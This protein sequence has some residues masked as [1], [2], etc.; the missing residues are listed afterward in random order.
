[1]PED[2][3]EIRY[4][5]DGGVARITLAAPDKLNSLSPA[6][7]GA[8]P[9]IV[10]RAQDGGARCILLSGEG[11]AFCS[12]ARLG[13]DGAGGGAGGRDLGNVIDT[14]YNPIARAFAD[15]SIPVVTALNG[16]AAGAGVG[17]ALS[18]DIVIAAR[19]AYLLLA[20]ANIGLVPDAGST[21]LVA[22]SVGR[23][24][25]LELALLAEKL[26]A[27]EAQTAGLIARVVSDD[28]LAEESAAVAARLASMPTRALG[29]IR[30]QVRLA[31]DA[32]LHASLEAE[33]DNQRIAG[34]TEDHREGVRA[35]MEKRPALFTG[36]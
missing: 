10:G 1:M 21:W 5:L 29:M 3:D 13:G 18:G 20:F 25:A 17:L 4:S 35:F 2:T 9:A 6:M 22:Q 24:R 27:E 19:S 12:G 7:L 26:P 8:L 23:A 36:T 28:E 33:R 31:L 16:L 15:S 34:Q 30:K 11:R 32:G 14:Y